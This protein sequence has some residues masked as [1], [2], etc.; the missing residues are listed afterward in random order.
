MKRLA[1]GSAIPDLE[2][3]EEDMDCNANQLLARKAAAIQAS[4]DNARSR[5]ERAVKAS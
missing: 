1:R 4:K 5:G 2:Q 3:G